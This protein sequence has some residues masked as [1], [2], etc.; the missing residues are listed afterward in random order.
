[1]MANNFKPTQI[2]DGSFSVLTA[3]L[4]DTLAHTF[5]ISSVK[6]AYLRLSP[7]YD[8]GVASVAF[9]NDPNAVMPAGTTGS[10]IIYGNRPLVIARPERSAYILIKTDSPGGNVQVCGGER[11]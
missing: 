7:D 4:P 9:S 6:G 5:A 10:I 8:T 3:A 1:M 2:E 11:G